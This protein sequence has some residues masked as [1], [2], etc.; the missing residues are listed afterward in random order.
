M[1]TKNYTAD[2]SR[3]IRSMHACPKNSG[4]R[5][6]ERERTNSYIVSL[7]CR[8][9]YVHLFCQCAIGSRM[10]ASYYLVTAGVL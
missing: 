7:R 10:I 6:H 1:I 9:F 3:T 5:V 8:H 2:L 4:V